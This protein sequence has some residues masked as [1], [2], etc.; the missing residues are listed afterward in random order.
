METS[1]KGAYVIAGRRV[2]KTAAWKASGPAALA[3]GNY[4]G[5]A[6]GKGR[7]D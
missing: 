1:V 2:L 4:T 7:D 5:A 6:S 3:A